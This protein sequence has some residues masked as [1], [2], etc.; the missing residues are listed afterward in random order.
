MISQEII[1][2]LIC[3]AALIKATSYQTNKQRSCNVWHIQTDINDSDEF[4]RCCTA[5]ARCQQT[6]K[7]AKVGSITII[8][9]RHCLSSQMWNWQKLQWKTDL[10]ESPSRWIFYPAGHDDMGCWFWYLPD[11]TEIS[12]PMSAARQRCSRLPRYLQQQ[13]QQQAELQYYHTTQNL[14]LLQVVI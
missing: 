5:A 3:T 9:S 8:N 2:L 11:D 6:S 1:Q 7:S 12:A 4:S 10:V 13:Q 14:L